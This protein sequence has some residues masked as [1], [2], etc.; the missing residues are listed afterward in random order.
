MG[1]HD[2]F[3]PDTEAIRRWLEKRATYADDR[4]DLG[5]H[6]SEST[7]PVIP[8]PSATTGARAARP[9]PVIEPSAPRPDYEALGRDVVDAVGGQPDAPGAPAE[10]VRP[11]QP[12]SPAMPRKRY[13]EEHEPLDL[14][15]SL[16]ALGRASTNYVFKPRTGVRSIITVILLLALVGTA[17]AA[18]LAWREQTTLTIALA[19]VMVVL[20]L[21]IWGVRTT[22]T[23]MELAVVRGQLETIH[24]GRFDV[25]DLSS[26]FTP[27]AVVGKPGKRG[28]KVY[29]ERPDRP[30]LVLDSSVV[31]PR[32]FT[33]VL[34]R[35]RPDLDPTR[36]G[37]VAI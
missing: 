34:Y 25:V 28:W 31:D 26:P 32:Q 16:E 6:R 21:V 24:D 22:A 9:S 27:V 7:A 14:D 37:D 19:I 10:P 13:A 1:T 30:L 12:P 11:A 23:P 29:I 33:T 15:A 18:Y 17:G 8:P 3:G 2:E 35:L 4:T 5:R 36:P 20:T